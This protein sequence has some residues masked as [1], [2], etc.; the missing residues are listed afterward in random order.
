MNKREY[1]GRWGAS[2]KLDHDCFLDPRFHSLRSLHLG[3]AIAI[4]SGVWHNASELASALTCEDNSTRAA[5]LMLTGMT[6]VAI[7][8]GAPAK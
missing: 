2:S 4:V 8:Y 7:I 3:F 5:S 6:I 1:C